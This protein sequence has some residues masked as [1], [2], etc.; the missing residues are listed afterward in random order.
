MRYWFFVCLL[1]TLPSG[2]HLINQ[3]CLNSSYLMNVVLLQDDVS[4]W[5]IKFVKPAVMKAIETDTEINYK[6]GRL[7]FFL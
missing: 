2:S 3:S 6:S 5:N 4:P 7:F 1:W